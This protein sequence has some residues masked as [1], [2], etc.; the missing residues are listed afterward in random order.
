[1][2]EIF[3]KYLAIS[4]II[5]DASIALFVLLQNPKRAINQAYWLMMT[6]I[7]IWQLSNVLFS[8][9]S[10]Q[11]IFFAE[12]FLDITYPF[13][14]F[15]IFLFWYF[16]YLFPDRE[17]SFKK[18]FFISIF[19]FIFLLLVLFTNWLVELTFYKDSQNR[20]FTYHWLYKI[21][22]FTI[23]TS[24]LYII[25]TLYKKIKEIK[26]QRWKIQLYYLLAGCILFS[27]IGITTNLIVPIIQNVF[28]GIELKN[29]LYIYNIGPSAS[30]IFSALVAYAILRHRLLAIKF[31]IQRKWFSIACAA[32]LYLCAMLLSI[33]TQHLQ[34]IILTIAIASLLFIPT[35]RCIA[36]F[37]QMIVKKERID[38]FKITSVE[39][40]FLATCSTPESFFRLLVGQIMQRIPLEKIQCIT[41]DSVNDYY[42]PAFRLGEGKKFPTHFR[43]KEKIITILKKTPRIF[44]PSIDCG[45]YWSEEE[46]A[47]LTEYCTQKEIALILPIRDPFR[48]LGIL[49]LGNRIDLKE[50]SQEDMLFLEDV[51]KTGNDMMKPI[52]TLYHAVAT[53]I[54]DSVRVEEI[55]DPA[56]K[57]KKRVS[58]LEDED[59]E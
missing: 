10:F 34:T 5:I 31:L 2:L 56:F 16:I 23:I 33:H 48:I 58:F 27:I 12:F 54:D 4:A 32:I 22:A 52:L 6:S 44:S 3:V 25:K 13:A 50:I 30:I 43:K 11:N 1:M 8:Y 55:I 14:G 29:Y 37:I 19:W 26:I 45:D 41:Y 7:N 17:H 39:K 53:R 21:Y 18:L 20:V 38:L 59:D 57:A 28:L 36:F 42:R 15:S 24:L 46:K 40:K 51:Q 49:F 9:Y 47:F 35:Q